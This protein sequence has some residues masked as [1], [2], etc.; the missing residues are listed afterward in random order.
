MW[1]PNR[2]QN[3]FKMWCETLQQFS[4]RLNMLNSKVWWNWDPRVNS[5]HKWLVMRTVFPWHDV[6]LLQY[7]LLICETK[8][9]I[10]LGLISRRIKLLVSQIWSHYFVLWL[11]YW[12]KSSLQIWI[13][14]GHHNFSNLTLKL[15]DKNF[16]QYGIAHLRINLNN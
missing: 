13:I 10:F 15:Y 7:F 14:F 8:T 12:Y 16:Q 9:S 5:R 3:E 6:I 2:S 11:W 4:S 1:N